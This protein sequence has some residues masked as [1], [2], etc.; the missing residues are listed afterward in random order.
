MCTWL[1]AAT[2]SK[3]TTCFALAKEAS[4]TLGQLDL[5]YLHQ[6]TYIKFAKRAKGVKQIRL[7]RLSRHEY[8][9]VATIEDLRVSADRNTRPT[10]HS[11]GTSDGSPKPPSDKVLPI[12][13]IKPRDINRTECRS[14]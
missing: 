13:L 5:S 3:E 6:R 2:V 9:R 4:K 12:A 14:T 1:K 7:S 10:R 11:N 8:L